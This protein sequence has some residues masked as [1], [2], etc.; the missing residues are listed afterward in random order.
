MKRTW[1]IGLAAALLAIL[2]AAY[3]SWPGHAPAGQPILIE[4][5]SKAMAGLQSEF[6][7]ASAGIRV[8]LLLSPT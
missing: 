6:N 8:I 5:D 3:F 4:L 2:A 1:K 7:R